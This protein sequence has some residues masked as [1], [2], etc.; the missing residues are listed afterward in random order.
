M[1]RDKFCDYIC[2]QVIN[3]RIVE[4]EQ[5]VPE[6]V[7]KDVRVTHYVDRPVEVERI[8]E[9]PQIQVSILVVVLCFCAAHLQGCHYAAISQCSN[10]S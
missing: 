4:V 3:E 8:V 9:V 6:I 7:H 1:A 5:E 10:A 2:S